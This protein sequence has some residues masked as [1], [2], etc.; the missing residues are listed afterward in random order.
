M[1]VSEGA[2]RSCQD[3]IGRWRSPDKWT[4]AKSHGKLSYKQLLCF[5]NAM[6]PNGPAIKEVCVAERMQAGE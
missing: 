3:K 2:S 6:K 4:K 1:Q 5:S